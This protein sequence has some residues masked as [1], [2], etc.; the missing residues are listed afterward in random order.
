MGP[1]VQPV[2][3]KS[4][5]CEVR[6]H[7]SRRECVSHKSRSHN[8]LHTS[9]IIAALKDSVSPLRICM[10]PANERPAAPTSISWHPSS[11]AILLGP[12]LSEGGQPEERAGPKQHGAHERP[13]RPF[14][15]REGAGPKQHAHHERPERRLHR[16][17][18]PAR[19]SCHT[20]GAPEIMSDQRA[21]HVATSRPRGT[22]GSSGLRA[23]GGARR[24]TACFTYLSTDRWLQLERPAHALLR[25]VK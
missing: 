22:R 17:H 1:R 16:E 11:P 23:G 21:L 20:S 8:S 2:Q 7:Q 6:A 12:A 9:H 24:Q 3:R 19:Y 14:C 4:S 13:E 10:P 5:T 15:R 18:A 25:K